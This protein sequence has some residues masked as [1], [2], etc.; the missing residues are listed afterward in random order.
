LLVKTVTK[1]IGPTLEWLADH[2]DLPFSLIEDYRYPG[3]SVCRM[4]GLPTRSGAELVDRLREAAADAGVELLCDAY[5]RSL[6]ASTDC[7][8]A[9]VEVERPDGSKERIGCVTLILACNEYGG[10]RD[11]VQRHIPELGNALYFCHEGN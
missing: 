5:V 2:Y 7:K 9:G 4:H 10:N 1:A 6:F 8:I 11:L 3:H